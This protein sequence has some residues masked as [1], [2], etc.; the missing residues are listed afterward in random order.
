MFRFVFGGSDA[1]ETF[2]VHIRIPHGFLVCLN[3]KFKLNNPGQNSLH[4]VFQDFL[5]LG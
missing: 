5:F 3:M 2:L 4:L 1:C